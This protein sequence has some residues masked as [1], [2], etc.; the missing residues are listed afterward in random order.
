MIPCVTEKGDDI[1]EIEGRLMCLRGYL[2]LFVLR[3]LLYPF[4]SYDPPD[5]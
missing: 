1:I 4:F 2:I 3:L 5:I